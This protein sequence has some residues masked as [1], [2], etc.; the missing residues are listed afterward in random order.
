M[1]TD[2]NRNDEN[3]GF[4]REAESLILDGAVSG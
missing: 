1:W 2:V 3:L 4:L